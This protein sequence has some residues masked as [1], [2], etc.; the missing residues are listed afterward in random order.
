MELA[1]ILLIYFLRIFVFV[2][3]I[4]DIFGMCFYVLDMFMEIRRAVMW[5]ATESGW[6]RK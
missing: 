4:M 2:Y 5:L 1:E 3:K 6:A